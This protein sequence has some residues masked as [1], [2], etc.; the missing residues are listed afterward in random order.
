MNDS[1]RT[2][3]GSLTCSCSIATS[4]LVSLKPTSPACT[5]CTSADS[6]PLGLLRIFGA[7]GKRAEPCGTWRVIKRVKTSSAQASPHSGDKRSDLGRARSAAPAQGHAHPA[8]LPHCS[9]LHSPFPF[10]KRQ[11][12][13]DSVLP[14]CPRLFACSL[15]YL[16]S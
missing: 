11:M 15:P 3:H 4:T 2:I 13:S 10:I 14:H 6:A 9:I 5:A 12:R 8:P 1:R 16:P 7:G